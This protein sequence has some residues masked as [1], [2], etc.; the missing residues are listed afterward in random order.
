MTRPHPAP[1]NSSNLAARGCGIR[2]ESAE[3]TGLQRQLY[4]HGAQGAKQ[5]LVSS[6]K[7]MVD[8]KKV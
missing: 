6:G 5:I 7:D 8:G 4:P 3:G 2:T 1:Q